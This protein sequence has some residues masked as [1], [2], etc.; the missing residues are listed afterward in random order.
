VPTDKVR[1]FPDQRSLSN[2]IR[3]D[4]GRVFALHDDMVMTRDDLRG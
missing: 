4:D 3:I 2:W 1:L